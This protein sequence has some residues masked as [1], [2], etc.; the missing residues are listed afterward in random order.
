VNPFR[1]EYSSKVQQRRHSN[2]GAAQRPSSSSPSRFNALE[3]ESLVTWLYTSIVT[4]ICCAAGSASP[5]EDGRPVLPKVRRR[6][7]GL[8]ERLLR[9]FGNYCRSARDERLNTPYPHQVGG[10]WICDKGAV[11]LDIPRGQR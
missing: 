2:D 6:L 10:I 8:R 5:P 1:L 3:V 11:D 7:Y 4:A 9:R